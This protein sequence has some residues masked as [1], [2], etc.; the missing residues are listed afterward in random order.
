MTQI[1]KLDATGNELP[2]DAIDHAILVINNLR[3]DV[4]RREPSAN[5]AAAMAECQAV[6]L[7]GLTW[8]AATLPEIQALAD[9]GN[10]NA[11][12][13]KTLF[14]NLPEYGWL[15]TSTPYAR[16]S[17][18]SSPVFAWGVLL[19]CGLAHFGYRYVVGLALPVSPLA[20]PA[21]QS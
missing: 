11:P 7:L 16:E 12:F 21:S 20:A 9:Y 15:W 6:D 13:A 10:P 17:D 14:P 1:L 8:R 2:S 3:I 19:H 4:R 5:H 18:P